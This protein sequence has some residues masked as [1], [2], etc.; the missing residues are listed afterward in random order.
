[1]EMGMDWKQ[2]IILIHTHII[3][4]AGHGKKE[5]GFKLGLGETCSLVCG[6]S[7]VEQVYEYFRIKPK[8]CWSILH[9]SFVL[10]VL[11]TLDP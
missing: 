8:I 2:Q 5:I 9:I 11:S 10:T 4:R 7:V 1:M 6:Y 3:F